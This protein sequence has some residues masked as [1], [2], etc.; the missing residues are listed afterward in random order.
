MKKKISGD[1][2][3]L[4]AI[5]DHTIRPVWSVMIPVYNCAVF[6]EDTLNCVLQQA[7]AT[8]KMEIV[9][10][11]DCSTDNPEE[12]VQRLGK[13]R[14]KYVRQSKNLGHTGNFE[15]C[16]A[17][18][19]G[20]Y[21]HLLHGDDRVLPGFYDEF[22]SLFKNNSSLMAAFCRHHYIDEDN[23]V[24]GASAEHMPHSGEFKHFFNQ[25]TRN[26]IIQ[27]PSVVVKRAVYEKIGMFNHRLSW[28]EDWE[29]WSRIGKNYSFGYINTILAEYRM[30]TKSNSGKYLLSGE[31]IRDLRRGIE[32]IN[33]FVEDTFEKKDSK[34]VATAYYASYAIKQAVYFLEKGEKQGARNQL[35]AA[36]L[37]SKNT[38]LNLQIIKLFLKSI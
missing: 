19:K 14:V 1:Y 18:S 12:V 13:G 35:K 30:H 37:M 15:T 25:I 22:T 7:P 26:Q 28:C 3:Y 8:D 24:M 34:K 31:N 5:T 27:T 32:I 36:F 6:L 4:N 21:V 29:M 16:L 10:V 2:E 11:D 17:L 20:I 9:V 33:S 23:V 38:R